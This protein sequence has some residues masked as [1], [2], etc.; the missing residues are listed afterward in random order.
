[1]DFSDRDDA[2]R[3]LGAALLA[4][5]GQDVVVLG[6]PRGGV[7]VAYQVASALGAPLDVIVVRK[8][9]L[10]WQPEVAMGA[11]GED[12]VMVTND[13]VI[14]MGGVTATE[15]AQEVAREREE[16]A[17]RSRRFREVAPKLTVAGRVAVI[18]DD[19]VATGA[20][21]RAACLVARAEG[22]EEVVLAVPVGAAETVAQLRDRL[23][24]HA[25][26]VLGRRPGLPRLLPGLRR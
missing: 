4:Y 3:R 25:G 16:V 24:E 2:G 26:A 12:G 6:L 5:H 18:V 23:P 1:M 11:V 8:L 7:A 20:T 10:P 13:S 22:A 9:G 17:R 15:L 21:A 14:A 19:G